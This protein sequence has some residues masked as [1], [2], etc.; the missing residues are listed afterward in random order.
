MLTCKTK[1]CFCTAEML[2]ETMSTTITYFADMGY[3]Q[4]QSYTK[5][6]GA[7]YKVFFRFSIPEEEMSKD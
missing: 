4:S 2:C 5:Y 6:D 3:T 1:E 7:Y